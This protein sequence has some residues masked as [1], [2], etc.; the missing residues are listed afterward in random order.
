[1]SRSM[2]LFRETKECV[3]N[4][5]TIAISNSTLYFWQQNLIILDNI[6]LYSSEDGFLQ[7]GATF[8]NGDQNE[9]YR[10]AKKEGIIF[11]RHE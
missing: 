3:C 6:H 7:H 5:C 9:I 11:I 10:I 4:E 2:S 1:M 8:V